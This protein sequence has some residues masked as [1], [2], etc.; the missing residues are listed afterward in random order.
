MFSAHGVWWVVTL[1]KWHFR[2]GFWCTTACLAICW[3]AIAPEWEDT[4]D[5]AAHNNF[6]VSIVCESHMPPACSGQ[7]YCTSCSPAYGEL[8]IFVLP[9]AM[10]RIIT[11]SKANKP[12]SWIICSPVWLW[13]KSPKQENAYFAYIVQCLFLYSNVNSCVYFSFELFMV[14]LTLH[15]SPKGTVYCIFITLVWWQ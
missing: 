11:Y 12:F 14:V 6:G 1:T 10:C 5:Q 15:C 9:Q 4:E 7:V 2:H 8:L 13:C 3:L